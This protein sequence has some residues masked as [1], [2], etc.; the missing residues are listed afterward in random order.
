VVIRGGTIVDGSGIPRY[1]ADLAIKNGRVALIS[2]RI[3]AHGA[4]ELDATGCIA[5]W[6][7]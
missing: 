7:Y 6:S 1:Q 5:P 2:G 3:K 4:K